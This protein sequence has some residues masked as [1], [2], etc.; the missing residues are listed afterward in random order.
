MIIL[1]ISLDLMNFLLSKI[2]RMLQRC[3]I[4]MENMLDLFKEE[5]EVT[6]APG[7]GDLVVNNGVVEFRNV[8]FSYV[9]EKSVLHNVSFVVPAGQSV[10]LVQ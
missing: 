10:A 6:D 1:I 9:P 5:A 8:S 3:F 2:S 7:A 4:D